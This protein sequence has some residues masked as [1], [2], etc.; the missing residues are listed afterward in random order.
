MFI[1][2]NYEDTCR[3]EITSWENVLVQIR[4]FSIYVF[5]ACFKQR[6]LL[7]I[8]CFNEYSDYKV[9]IIYY[10]TIITYNIYVYSYHTICNVTL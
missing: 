9:T 4:F 5:S 6:I 10:T 8:S 3:E 2:Y 7:C 1:D